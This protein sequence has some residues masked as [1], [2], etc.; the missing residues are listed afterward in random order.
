MG[1]C[2]FY[3]E[4]ERGLCEW[5]GYQRWRAL[6]ARHTWKDLELVHIVA[7][8]SWGVFIVI[9]KRS[10]ALTWFHF[11]APGGLES[12][13][14]R[15]G[16]PSNPQ[17]SFSVLTMRCVASKCHWPSPIFLPLGISSCGSQVTQAPLTSLNCPRSAASSS[18]QL[19]SQ[20][21]YSAN[22]AKQEDYYHFCYLGI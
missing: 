22:K 13:V 16:V 11:T 9:V 14:S 8:I 3:F 20:L 4:M 21:E 18:R 5:M 1:V 17:L 2:V 19:C 12:L 10:V 7:L 6:H 15:K